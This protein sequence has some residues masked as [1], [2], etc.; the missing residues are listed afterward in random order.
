MNMIDPRQVERLDLEHARPS[1]KTPQKRMDLRALDLSLIDFGEAEHIDFVNTNLKKDEIQSLQAAQQQGIQ[2]GEE[3]DRSLM[4][5][6]Q[7]L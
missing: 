3:A 4:D 7:L 2:G 5:D 1:E 6:L